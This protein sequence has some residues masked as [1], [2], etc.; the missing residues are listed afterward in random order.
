MMDTTPPH[1]PEQS[2]RLEWLE[3]NG[4]GGWASSS[5]IGMHTRRYH[6]LL[7]AA[8]HPPAERI[9]LVS[10][11]DESIITA[12]GQYELS[13]NEYRGSVIHPGGYRYFNDFSKDLFPQW[14]YTAAGIRLTRTVAMVH[15]E[16]TTLIIYRVEAAPAPFHLQLLPLISAKDYH[17]LQHASTSLR[18]DVQFKEG[19]FHNQ[20]FEGAPDIYI[21]VPGSSYQHAPAWHYH[22]NYARDRERGQEFEEDL[23]NHGKIVTELQQGDVLGI[24]VSTKSPAGRD[25]VALLAGEKTRREDLLAAAGA[26][27]LAAPGDGGAAGARTSTVSGSATANILRPLVLA[28]DQFIVR[29][30]LPGTGPTPDLIIGSTVI[31]GYHWFTDWSRDTM[32]S[33]PGLCLYT[34][35]PEAAKKILRAFAG[36]V[37]MGMLPNRFR[38]NHEPPEYNNVDGTLWFFI[39]VHHYLRSTGDND[40]VLRE[41][42]PVLKEIIDWHYK[43]TRY[44]IHVAEDG[45]LYA[46]EKGQQLT[47]MDARIG[48]W[49]VTPR[50]GK[51]VEIQALW[52]NALL[53][54]S[55]LLER[56]GQTTGAAHFAQD[57]GKVRDSFTRLFWYEAGGYCYDLID[58]TGRPDPSCRPN[59][60]LALSL[61]YPLADEDQ[62]KKILQIVT[63]QLATPVGLRSLS[64]KDPRYIGSYDGD[65]LKRDGSYHQGTVWPWLLGPYIDA[66]IRFDPLTGQQ[67]AARIIRD[68]SYHLQ[69]SC[70]GSVSEIMDGDAPHHPKG[71]VAQAW[72]VAEILRV[73][74]AYNL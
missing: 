33:L 63:G 31:A 18:W 50:M 68:F 12:E 61:P 57:A 56:N 5:I 8:T 3:T 39:A 45:L 58:E 51:P 36:S 28:A 55:A 37:S 41:I 65:I 66:I 47:W 17:S 23:L 10:R 74:K 71:C 20:P 46:G 19:V 53:I 24:I 7:I 27:A 52:Y 25:A 60:L 73:V 13:T 9:N 40:F 16:N 54:F 43:G 21:S 26:G 29:R 32:I 35:R 2:G 14:T 1:D 44:H 67:Q 11:L 15:G 6:G 22:F 70:I 48:D 30:E 49:V 38:D 42:L 34:G 59:Q 69:E 72:S 62:G 64:S 4:L